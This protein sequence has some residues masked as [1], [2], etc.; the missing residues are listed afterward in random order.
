MKTYELYAVLITDDEKGKKGTGTL[1][2]TAGS[3]HFYVLTCAHVIYTSTSVKL[4][5]IISSEEDAKEI[6]VDNSHFHYSPIDQPTI[7]DNESLHT[8][9]IAIIEC[10]K[11]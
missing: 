3:E 9:D 4:S 7:I 8:C 1:F 6:I 11:K 5:I 2:Y 10:E